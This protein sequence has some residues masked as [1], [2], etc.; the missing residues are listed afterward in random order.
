MPVTT[1]SGNGV[2]GDAPE[3]VEAGVEAGVEGGV[4]AGDDAEGED[5]TEAGPLLAGVT[6]WPRLEQPATVAARTTRV[7]CRNPGALLTTPA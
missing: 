3:G 2:G 5:G 1:A 4:E 7:A 6:R